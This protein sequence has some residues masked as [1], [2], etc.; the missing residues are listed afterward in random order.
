MSRPDNI[1]QKC[2]YALKAI[3]ELA[4]RDEPSSIKIQEIAS[5]QKM[6][7]R[8]L[9]VIMSELKHGNFVISRRGKQGGYMLAKPANQITIGEVIGFLEGS[10][11]NKKRVDLQQQQAKGD[12][13]FT[14][15]WEKVSREIAEIYKSI[16]FADLVEREIKRRKE[17]APDYVI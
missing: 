15:L 2:K 17:Y 8:F 7:K 11:F 4:F 1:S 12:Y 13:V 10:P 14:W 16:T 5:A 3:F 9:E 6:P